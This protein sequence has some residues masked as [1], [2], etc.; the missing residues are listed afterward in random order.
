MKAFSTPTE[1]GVP[2]KRDILGLSVCDLPPQDV[3]AFAERAATMPAGQTAIT[4]LDAG[5]AKLMLGDPRYR[6]ALERQATLP[7]GRH[8][9][10]ACRLLHGKAF[11]ASLPATDFVPALL[12][13]IDRPMRV[14]MIG[15]KHPQALERAADAFARHAPWHRFLAMADG[16]FDRAA[17]DVILAEV[18]EAGADILLVALTSPEQET[19]IDR[20][21]GPGHARLVLGVGGLFDRVA[22]G[23]VRQAP[24]APSLRQRSFFGDPALF[25]HVLRYRMK[26]P[27]LADMPPVDGFEAGLS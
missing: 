3:L 20:H 17:S 21:V 23:G 22:A 18:R 5:K 24:E 8:I 12:T 16:R 2:P 7:E 25:W 19:W 13:Y 9:D 1:N 4:F 15:G 11:T 10:I 27:G 6:A 26:R 14:A